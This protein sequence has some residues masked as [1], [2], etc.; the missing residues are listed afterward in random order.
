MMRAQ[1]HLSLVEEELKKF[2]KSVAEMSWDLLTTVPPLV[3]TQ[4]SQY[5][6]SLHQKED[7]DAGRGDDSM[8]YFRPVLFSSY[9]GRVAKKGWV[10]NRITGKQ[11]RKALSSETGS[12][13]KD[14]V[15][16]EH[17]ETREHLETGHGQ[18]SARH[19]ESVLDRESH[20]AAGENYSDFVVVCAEQPS[21]TPSETP[22]VQSALS[23]L[24][25]PAVSGGGEE[26]TEDG[27]VEYEALSLLRLSNR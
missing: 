20:D 15:H 1:Q 5:S 18:N 22:S 16:G 4:P 25:Q 21:E 27:S 10:T 9:E 17:P 2:T 26:E 12:G 23:E 14:D 7:W 8:V 3:C 19:E 24:L 6:R 11:N 13:Q